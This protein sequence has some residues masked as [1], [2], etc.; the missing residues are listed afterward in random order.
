[1]VAVPVTSEARFQHG[2]EVTL[3]QTPPQQVLAPFAP[4]YSIGADGKTFLI[5]SELTMA[6]YRT[7]TVVANVGK[8]SP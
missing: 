5:R 7:I 6:A 8:R 2:R 4:S 1:M 3:F